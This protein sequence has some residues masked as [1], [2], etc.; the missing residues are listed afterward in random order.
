MKRW[1]N[2]PQSETMDMIYDHMEEHIKVSELQDWAIISL[3]LARVVKQIEAAHN[4]DRRDV[5]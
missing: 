2:G 4:A 1:Y 5:Q 3:H